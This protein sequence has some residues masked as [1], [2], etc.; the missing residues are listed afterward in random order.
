MTKFLLIAAGALVVAGALAIGG[1]IAVAWT[2][3]TPPHT[4]A[5]RDGPFEIRDYPPLRVAEVVRSGPRR[6][7]V[8]AGF[9]PLAR[10]IFARER[11]G[12][13]IAMT[14]PV[15]QTPQGEGRWAVQF[16][17]PSS[18]TLADLPA[19]AGAEVTLHEWPA[20]RRAVIRFGGVATDATIAEAEARLRGWLDRQG[21][22]AV[23]APL[24]AYYNDPLTPGFLRRNEVLLTLAQPAT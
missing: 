11:E 24:Y 12:A 10:Y 17:M 23:G 5:L 2:V 18:Y 14:A 19:P 16:I 9:G 22:Q 13:K 15:T 20:A 21:L 4:L 1:W 8:R 6:E 7:A 3:A